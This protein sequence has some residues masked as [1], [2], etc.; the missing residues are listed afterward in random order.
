M[1]LWGGV[2]APVAVLG[3]IALA[4]REIGKGFRRLKLP[5]IS[6][7]LLCGAAAGPDVLA[8]ISRDALERLQF[9]DQVAIAFIG[10]A[11][12]VELY[13]KEFRDR[14]RPILW[15][16]FGIAAVTLPAIALTFRSVAHLVP[17]LASA[18]TGAMAAA[19]I[20]AGSVLVARSPSSAIAIIKELRAWGPFTRLGLGVTVLM[21]AVVIV[22]FTI[23]VE[24]AD[25]TLHGTEQGLA[26]TVL[27][28]FVQLLASG[29][30]GVLVGQLVR[31]ILTVLHGRAA[32]VAILALG[33]AVFAGARALH[34]GAFTVGGHEILLEPLLICMIA[35]LFVANATRRREQFHRLLD[36]QS[37]VVF[38]LFF[39][40]AGASLSLEVLA[41]TW[42]IALLLFGVRL[43]AIAVGAA[44]GA[45]ISGETP[46]TRRL[47]WMSFIT[48]AGVGLGLAKEVALEFPGWGEELSTVIIGVIVLN[49]MAGPPAYRWVLR[50]VGE[51]HPRADA[52]GFDGVRDAIIFGHEGQAMALARQLHEHGWNVKLAAM[53]GATFENPHERGLEIFEVHE[54]SAEVL[55]SLD[56]SRAECIVSLLDDDANYRVCELAYEHYGTENLVVR[57]QH[58]TEFARFRELGV[59]VVDPATAM[60][61]LLDHMVRS[62]RSTSLLLGLD[63]GNDVYDIQVGNPNLHGMHIRELT[64]PEDALV[65][66]LRRGHNTLITHGRT[67]LHHGDWVTILGS[68][69]S[70]EEIAVRFEGDARGRE[71]T[72]A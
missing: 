47:L 1:D 53:E 34:D 26:S 51:A 27:L 6:G 56:A 3:V 45:T 52:A 35:G 28:L 13:L 12:G 4:S 32:S 20:L 61:S 71:A 64:L 23:S 42:Q 55:A 67:E 16:T 69:S 10:F 18:G 25:V 68:V 46:S 15:V 54:I 24:I 41:R 70:L 66:S 8:M 72:S 14:I 49:Q 50:R 59:V 29:L 31:G 17:G 7:F 65:L 19:G 5:L 38:V 2:L 62:P 33:W 36:R 63:E 21:D 11:A 44:L 39:T 57:A 22:L 40:L 37:P 60:I 58:A 48:Q 30:A 43:L 9:V